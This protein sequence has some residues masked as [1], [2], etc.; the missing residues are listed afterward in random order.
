MVPETTEK[1]VNAVTSRTSPAY[2][3]LDNPMMFQKPIWAVASRGHFLDPDTFNTSDHSLVFSII[4]RNRGLEKERMNEVWV[5]PIPNLTQ[6]ELN[7]VTDHTTIELTNRFLS[8]TD[9]YLTNGS[10]FILEVTT[11]QIHPFP[12][13]LSV[14]TFSE[15]SKQG[16]IMATG[17]L[18]FLY[19]LIIFEIIDRTLA[20][21]IGATAAIAC[22]TLIG[23]VSTRQWI[24]T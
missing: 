17:V 7:V 2:I 24:L 10:T 16:I 19:V 1:W 20:S 23:S 13:S 11:D 14:T 8:E 18:L 6:T 12:I 21:M 9:F 22:L 15:L 4:R 5:V 3:E